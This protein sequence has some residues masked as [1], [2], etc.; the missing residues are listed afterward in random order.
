MQAEGR[1]RAVRR[2]PDDP[3]V[4]VMASSSAAACDLTYHATVAWEDVERLGDA[5]ALMAARGVIPEST[6]DYGRMFH[7]GAARP[8]RAA[9]IAFWHNPDRRERWGRLR[10]QPSNPIESP[11]MAFEGY[12]DDRW[13]T[14]SAKFAPDRKRASFLIDTAKHPTDPHRRAALERYVGLPVA[15]L[16]EAADT[17][18]ATATKRDPKPVDDRRKATPADRPE[19]AAPPAPGPDAHEPRAAAPAAQPKDTTLDDTP[20]SMEALLGELGLPPR[21]YPKLA[22]RAAKRRGVAGR[23]KR[24]R[25]SRDDLEQIDRDVWRAV[26]ARPD[27]TSEAAKAAA[28]RVAAATARAA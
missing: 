6:R 4:I 3:V 19:P 20:I 24:G 28:R 1:A 12:S 25:A 9:Q 22:Q 11:I 14:F 10:E 15:E 21:E 16:A 27:V 18:A 2:G 13:S 23:F 26:L 7:G 17:A 8:D 5:T